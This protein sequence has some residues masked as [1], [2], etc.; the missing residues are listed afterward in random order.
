MLRSSGYSSFQFSVSTRFADVLKSVHRPRRIRDS[1]E[2]GSQG[3]LAINAG[4]Q[5]GTKVHFK[6]T[7][8]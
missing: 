7:N 4:L 2:S 3:I 5:V 8:I 1:Q 6:Y